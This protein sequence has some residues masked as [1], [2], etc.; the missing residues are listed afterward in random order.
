MN[1]TTKVLEYILRMILTMKKIQ[2]FPDGTT[3]QNNDGMFK[4]GVERKLF[5]NNFL[6]N[7]LGIGT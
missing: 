4:Y 1:K 3:T 2:L 5:S 7:L 6:L